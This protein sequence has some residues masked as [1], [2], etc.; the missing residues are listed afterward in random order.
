MTSE[1]ILRLRKLNVKLRKFLLAVI[2]KCSITQVVLEGCHMPQE[3][4]EDMVTCLWLDILF[5]GACLVSVTC[6]KF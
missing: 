2:T 4:I 1:V 3:R 5:H 6:V